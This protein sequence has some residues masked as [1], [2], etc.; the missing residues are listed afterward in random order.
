MLGRIV[1]FG[2][3]GSVACANLGIGFTRIGAGVT[4]ST[5]AKPEL[6][7][8][9][10]LSGL[11]WRSN[12]LLRQFSK[13]QAAPELDISVLNDTAKLE[14][15]SVKG[16]LVHRGH[17][18]KVGYWLLLCAGAVF[19]MIILGGYTRLSKSGLSMVKWKPI[20]YSY[21]RSQA[22]WEEEFEHYKVRSNNSPRNSLNFS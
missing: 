17:E 19:G 20:E 12:S 16:T 6:S 13:K 21:P 22:Q 4:R 8:A 15:I 5:S 3:A 11:G 14:D 10:N 9:Y 7:A 18:K 2:R 1:V